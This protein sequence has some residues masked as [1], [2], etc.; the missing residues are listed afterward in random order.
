MI[1]VEFDD[2]IPTEVGCPLY[3]TTCIVKWEDPMAGTVA[4]LAF[5]AGYRESEHYNLDKRGGFDGAWYL[6]DGGETMP[7]ANMPPDFWVPVSIV[8]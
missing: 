4:A 1:R 8:W 7:L 6:N 3:G 2:W 5:Y